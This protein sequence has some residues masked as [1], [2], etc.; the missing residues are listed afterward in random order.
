MRESSNELVAMVDALREL[1]ETVGA[2]KF[3]MASLLEADDWSLVIKA[4]ALLEGAVSYMLSACVDQRL[5]P[6]F[7]RLELGQERTGKVAFAKAL[8]LLTSEQRRFIR[9]LS[10]LRNE[11][12]HDIR[13]VTFDLKSHVAH[14][15]PDQ[16]KNFEA[17]L[18]VDI[19]DAD[20]SGWKYIIKE[21]PKF[22][23]VGAVMRVIVHAVRQ[24]KPGDS[25]RPGAG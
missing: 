5:R 12:V 11:L 13:N 9:T 23:V 25:P 16:R 14:L 15:H 17:A 3:L 7:S 18:L 20:Q 19:P 24:A 6:L 21:D 10:E 22:A 1:E 4:H 8:D 2:P